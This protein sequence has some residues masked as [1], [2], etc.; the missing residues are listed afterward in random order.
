MTSY[1]NALTRATPHAKKLL[2]KAMLGNNIAILKQDFL[3]QVGKSEML[4]RITTTLGLRQ[5]VFQLYHKTPK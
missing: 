2:I 4:Q 5:L 3:N 1:L